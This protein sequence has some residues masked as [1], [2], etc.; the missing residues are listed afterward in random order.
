MGR[1]TQGKKYITAKDLRLGRRPRA[2]APCAQLVCS[3]Q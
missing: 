1:P 3:V 2:T